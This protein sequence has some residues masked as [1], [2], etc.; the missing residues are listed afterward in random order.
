MRKI[1]LMCFPLLL[2]ACSGHSD[3]PSSEAPSF[4]NISDSEQRKQTEAAVGALTER[5]RELK[6]TSEKYG[7]YNPPK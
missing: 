5:Q 1:V 7:S 6:K 4:S 2:A 3:K